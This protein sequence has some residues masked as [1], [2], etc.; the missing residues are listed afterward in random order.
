MI[1][2]NYKVA[3]NAL[4]ILEDTESQIVFHPYLWNS[5]AITTTEGVC[6]AGFVSCA[7]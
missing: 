2:Y 1:I 5:R 4:V 3:Q 6:L 7:N